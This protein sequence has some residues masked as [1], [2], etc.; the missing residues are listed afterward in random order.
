MAKVSRRG[1]F[2]LDWQKPS[3]DAAAR[4]EDARRRKARVAA[5]WEPGS[6]TLLRALEPLAG[7]VCDMAAVGHRMDV[8]DV[9][10]GDGNVA[11]EADARGARVAACDITAAMVDRGMARAIAVDAGVAWQRGDAEDLPYPDER[12]DVVLSVLGVALAPRPRR[13]ARELV[14]VLRP[15]GMLVV[16]SP[17]PASLFALASAVPLT[18][19][20]EE[21]ALRHLAGIEAEVREHPLRLEFESLGAAWEAVSGPFGL[22]PDARER[23]DAIVTER[24]PGPGP[25]GMQDRWLLVLARRP[26]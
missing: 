15:G 11:L 8:L 16:A 10:A 13:A 21:D 12:F 24:S 14:R 22:P 25:I 6:P 23:F 20:I 3:G 7:V 9:G 17:A 19:G 2:T 4:A 26:S 18:W 5:R 1:L